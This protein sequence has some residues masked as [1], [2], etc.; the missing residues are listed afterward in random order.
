MKTIPCGRF[1]TTQRLR[2]TKSDDLC[3]CWVLRHSTCLLLILLIATGCKP[4]SDEVQ[5]GEPQSSQSP[6]SE[7]ADVPSQPVTSKAAPEST[8]SLES[9]TDVEV[10]QPKYVEVNSILGDSDESKVS[11]RIR[12]PLLELQQAGVLIVD[13]EFYNA[14]VAD[15]KLPKTHFRPSPGFRFVKSSFT[16]HESKVYGAF[17]TL[18]KSSTDLSETE[19]Q[20]SDRIEE[21]EITNWVPYLEPALEHFRR[22]LDPAISE[23]LKVRAADWVQSAMEE[24]IDSSQKINAIE[25]IER[26]QQLQQ[27]FSSFSNEPLFNAALASLHM[28]AGNELEARYYFDR[29]LTQFRFKDYPARIPAYF[30]SRA[31][32]IGSRDRNDYL[33]QSAREFVAITYWLENDLGAAP[34]QHEQVLWMAEQFI[35]KL[36]SVRDETMLKRFD[37]EIAKIHRLPK[38]L[39]M[40]IRGKA[41]YDLAILA[42]LTGTPSRID[43]SPPAVIADYSKRSASYYSTAHQL[44]SDNPQAANRM[45]ALVHHGFIN[46]SAEKWF[47][48]STKASPNAMEVYGI[49]LRA[50]L[51]EL[52]NGENNGN[53][54]RLLP[55]I[56]FAL[57]HS[58]DLTPRSNRGLIALETIAELLDRGES[59][60]PS[61]LA[62]GLEIADH[63]ANHPD[64]YF[65]GKLRDVDYFLTAKAVLA[66]RLQKFLEAD[67]ALSQAD[68]V[69]QTAIFRLGSKGTS[70]S[71]FRARSYAMF[72]EYSSEAKQL[73]ELLA[74]PLDERL[75][76][77]REIIDLCQRVIDEEPNRITRSYFLQSLEKTKLER[78]FATGEVAEVKIDPQFL[79][80]R[81]SDFRQTQFVDESTLRIDNQAN[82]SRFIAECIAEF[83]GPKIITCDIQLP[84]GNIRSALKGGDPLFDFAPTI[85]THRCENKTV[86]SGVGLSRIGVVETHDSPPH[87]RGRC[88]LP[89]L[90][91]SAKL[92]PGKN[93]LQV[94][95]DE[96]YIEFYLNGCFVGRTRYFASP[97]ELSNLLTFSQ[98]HTRGTGV[99]DFSNIRVQSLEGGSPPIELDPGSWVNHYENAIKFRP[100]DPW[101]QFWLGVSKHADGEFN[102]ALNAYQTSLELGNQ[103]RALVAYWKGDALDRLSKYEQAYQQYQIAAKTDASIGLVISRKKGFTP[104]RLYQNWAAFRVKWYEEFRKG[105]SFD[106]SA[107]AA[108]GLPDVPAHFDTLNKLLSAQSL[109]LKK[110]FSSAIRVAKESMV[111]IPLEQE[112]E[113]IKI[114]RAFQSDN[115]YIENPE[116]P[117][118]YLL[119]PKHKAVPLLE[120]TVR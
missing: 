94:H 5:P 83:P 80:W 30:A 31:T 107:Y 36:V 7:V 21:H 33:M 39:R 76:V 102:E 82:S 51:Y 119:F 65:D 35:E 89:Y 40:M 22:N 37:A 20:P 113:A 105:Q 55:A 3:S 18:S 87:L 63:F 48:E 67:E 46:E 112:S 56:D 16:G 110:D 26:G 6:S 59:I 42:E 111:N 104:F 47:T 23:D 90:F 24:S 1:Y 114:I 73:S 88:W 64:V 108:A 58:S 95:V 38:W 50:I 4:K 70:L 68:E 11:P 61:L 72:S 14:L 101:A 34:N 77:A 69:D 12:K 79:L 52:D 8:A 118:F 44:R 99:V 2:L 62:R 9:N 66:I 100:K 28:T 75:K 27:E 43:G 81:F 19:Y 17:P 45:L 29:A 103:D 96:S 49:Q 117:P 85:M 116:T 74:R 86:R 91:M 54:D 53:A 13:I 41:Y 109:A 15:S 71:V 57:R 60:D 98:R 78:R 10:D 25:L 84:D 120:Q 93:Q 106:N 32:G 97:P 92:E 115:C